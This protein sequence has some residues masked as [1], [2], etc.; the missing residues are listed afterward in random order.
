[1]FTRARL[2]L[3]SILRVTEGHQS[4]FGPIRN[5]V[6]D[7]KEK[8]MFSQVSVHNRPRGYSFTARSCYST[9][10]THPTG[11]LS[12]FY[13]ISTPKLTSFY[14]I[15]KQCMDCIHHVYY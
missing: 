6:T 4:G 1:M 9:V 15:M 12:C 14:T 3:L 7:R 13:G 5:I 10:S 11:M 2:R 8:V